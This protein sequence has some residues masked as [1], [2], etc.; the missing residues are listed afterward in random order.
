MI[1]VSK[2]LPAAGIMPLSAPEPVNIPD[3]VEIVFPGDEEP[4]AP[5]PAKEEKFD[6]NMADCPEASSIAMDLIMKVDQDLASRSEWEKDYRESLKYLG[7]KEESGRT[8]PWQGACATVVPVMLEGIV[9]FQ[10]RALPK[11]FPSDGPCSVSVANN[12][13]PNVAKAVK[14]CQDDYNRLL[15]LGMPEL[16]D[17]IDALLFGYANIGS[18]FVHCYL[19]ENLG[20]VTV[21]YVR[22][23][24][25]ILPYASNN[26]TTCNRITERV[27]RTIDEI[28]S[29]M[30]VG[31]YARIPIFAGIEDISQIEAAK[32]RISGQGPG[33]GAE[34]GL[35]LYQIQ[36]NLHIASD[37]FK[38][39]NG[40]RSPYL[41]TLDVTTNGVLAIRRNWHRGDPKRLRR[42][43][44]VRFTY[45]PGEGSMGM[46]QVQLVGQLSSSATKLQRQLVDAGSLANLPGGLKS[47]E[48]RISDPG[49]IAPGTWKD[50]Q[51]EPEMLEKAF[52]KL[53]Y[54][55][56]SVVLL[57]LMKEIKRDAQSFN[58]TSD[59]EISASSQNA[60][61][62][63]TL[64]IIE[65]QTEVSNAVQKRMHTSMGMVLRMIRA[66]LNEYDNDV[67]K[68]IFGALE[69][70][71]GG[72]DKILLT[73]SGDPSSSTMSQRILQLDSIK[74]NAVAFPGAFNIEELMRRIVVA[75]GMPDADIL[76]P[77]KSQ[78]PI[79]MS[80]IEEQMALLGA[81]K[82]VKAFQDQNHQAHLTAHG[83]LLTDPMYQQ[84]LAN[85]PKAKEIA[86][87]IMAHML[88]HYV[89]DYY[90]QI[91]QQFGQKLPPLGTEL[92]PQIQDSLD[93]LVAQAAQKV[94]QLHASQAHQAAAQQAQ[95]DP[96]IA[97]EQQ[98]LQ[99]ES[100]S[101]D[102][103]HVAQMAA[104]QS[105]H[106]LGQQKLEVDKAKLAQQVTKEDT[107]AQIKVLGIIAPATSQ[108]S[109]QEAE[110]QYQEVEHE[111]QYHKMATDLG[112]IGLDHL[113]DQQGA[114]QQGQQS[115]ADRQHDA[116]QAALQRGHEVSQAD[117]D[118]QQESDQADQQRQHDASI[119]S[120]Q[121]Q[122]SD[123]SPE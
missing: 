39:P 4:E 25:M 123:S 100:K 80:L 17:E 89:F 8:T 102:N 32:I 93:E 88:E 22:A 95:Q 109:S 115:D 116:Q 26:L 10:S 71:T 35:K 31:V 51:C 49:P 107:D 74:Q 37:K 42:D 56:P 70:L 52:V 34:D 119:A 41:V 66:F 110:R 84:Q 92:P 23:E 91:E 122:S 87:G 68:A 97:L 2:P 63:T 19:D 58:S 118:R 69:A 54:K 38:K 11:L 29:L 105:K 82:P 43:H 48:A 3:D 81:N 53:P 6:D 117:L 75:M 1:S 111:L 15:T 13:D 61:V 90:Q 104:L 106:D 72:P 121:R 59:L 33:V 47:S 5:R 120:L 76:V 44:Y 73:P 113:N 86:A 103:K 101:V 60:P 99:I 114:D 45:V 55:E 7:L 18:G 65:R 94:N 9:R 16:Q 83:A 30:D 108:I 20:R 46:G 21:R 98:K 62:G 12:T 64:A 96:A 57:E 36:V 78:S 85:N 79:E 112:S 27:R 50:V 40:G 77:N 14:Q 28:E 67:Y 24:D